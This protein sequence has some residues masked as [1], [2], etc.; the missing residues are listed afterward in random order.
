MESIGQTGP[1]LTIERQD[2]ATSVMLAGE[3][4]LCEAPQLREV[5]DGINAAQHVLFDLTGVTYLDSSTLRVFA[6]FK[7][8]SMGLGGSTAIYYG[9][10]DRARRLMGLSEVVT[11]LD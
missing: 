3:W 8:R 10:N 5:L 9:G 4:D 1:S 11:L 7:H 2:G 6:E